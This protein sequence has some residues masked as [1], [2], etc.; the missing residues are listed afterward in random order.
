M[1]DE[2]TEKFKAH[3]EKEDNEYAPSFETLRKK[4][5]EKRQPLIEDDPFVL[6]GASGIV[7]EVGRIRRIL[8]G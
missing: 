1:N 4:E 6:L 5:L 3:T 8:R 2:A 7:I